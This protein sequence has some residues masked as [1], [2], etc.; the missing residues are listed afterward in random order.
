MQTFTVYVMAFQDGQV[1]EDTVIPNDTEAISQADQYEFEVSNQL[2]PEP[3]DD[4]RDS[5]DTED[6][7][8]DDDIFD[9][10]ESMF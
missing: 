1:R 10:H 7:M 2:A 9:I 3:A 6:E 5:S 8:E 4:I